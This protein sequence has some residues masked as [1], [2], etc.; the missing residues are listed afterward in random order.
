MGLLAEWTPPLLLSTILHFKK[1]SKFQ[2]L[3][4]NFVFLAHVSAYSEL[5]FSGSW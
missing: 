3:K 4:P 1:T 2:R 5:F